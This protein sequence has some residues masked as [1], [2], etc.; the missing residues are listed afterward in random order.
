LSNGRTAA[1]LTT[2]ASLDSD[3]DGFTNIVEINAGVYPG[4]PASHPA[5]VVDTMGPTLAITTS[6]QTVTTSSITISGTATDS[7]RGNSGIQQVMVNGVAASGGTAA[8]SATAS[9]SRA[10]TL[11]AGANTITVIASDNSTAH[12]ATTHAF[13]I[14]H[15]GGTPP[16]APSPDQLPSFSH[17]TQITNPYFP[18][19]KLKRHILEGT[20]GGQTVRVIRTLKEDTKKFKVGNQKVRTL[21]MEDRAFVDGELEEVTLDYFAQDDDGTVYY[22][23]EDV[24]IYNKG[25]VVSHEG[26]WLY[27]V[28]TKQLGVIMPADPKVGT[29]F[30]AESVNGITTED[31]VVVSFGETV[32]VPAGKFKNCLKIQETPSDG[33]VEYKYYAPN[34]GVIKEVIKDGEINLISFGRRGEREEEE[35]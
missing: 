30:Q 8:T 12:N 4:D 1:A 23:G 25:K 6:A 19:I 2:I 26:A 20:V 18:L 22:M 17:S 9:W 16:P 35:D 5:P 15:K 10:V 7:G 14:T 21:I 34:V 3:G 31:E 24:N 28:H 33:T 27:G 32:T 13:T 29:K 11:N